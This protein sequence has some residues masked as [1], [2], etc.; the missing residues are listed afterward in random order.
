MP[1]I[2]H[3][4]ATYLPIKSLTWFYEMAFRK[5]FLKGLFDATR[6]LFLLYNSMQ[7]ECCRHFI[8]SDNKE[9]LQQSCP[10]CPYVERDF[11]TY[12]ETSIFLALR[13]TFISHLERQKI[14]VIYY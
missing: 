12:K 13:Q 3:P 5:D 11:I 1:Q 7:D 8:K 4:V 10:A 14:N 9:R 6:K 2:E